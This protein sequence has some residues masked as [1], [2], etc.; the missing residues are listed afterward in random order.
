LRRRLDQQRRR[1]HRRLALAVAPNPDGPLLGRAP[2]R[3]E[4]SERTR[5]VSHGGMGMIARLVAAVG[6]AEE[7]DEAIDLLKLHRPYHESDHVL[8]LAYNALCGGIRLD[9]IESRRRDPVFLDG[10]GVDCLPDPTTAGDFCRRFDES[11][12]MALQEA[13]NRVRLD[14]V[15]R[16]QPA[17]FF[18]QTARI[19]ADASIVPTDGETKQG[20]DIAYNGVWGYSALVVS[21]AVTA[22]VLYNALHGASRPS[23]EGV[24]PLYDRS[25]DLCRRAGFTDIL[26]RGDTDFSLTSEFDRW[27]GDEVR[28]VFGYDARANMIKQAENIAEVVLSR[29]GRPGRAG[30]RHPAPH[31]TSQRQRPHRP[32]AGL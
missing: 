22:E 16:A 24:I 7:I 17:S 19:D 2:I 4:L 3:Y 15:W 31:P 11:S 6:L 26:L 18:S 29:T 25:I 27:D 8:N 13:I 23:H 28:F 9:D 30:D 20:M 10:L 21:L 12:I 14:K 32:P 5:G 1:I